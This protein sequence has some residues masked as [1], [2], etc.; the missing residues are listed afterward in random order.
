MPYE[1]LGPLFDDLGLHKGFES[2]CDARREMAATSI[3][4]A[5]EENGNTFNSSFGTRC[6][7]ENFS[8]WSFGITSKSHQEFPSWRSG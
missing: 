2:G 6:G 3:G 5:E 1:L 4:G 8:L 7:I